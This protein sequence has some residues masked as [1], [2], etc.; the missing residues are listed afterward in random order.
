MKKSYPVFFSDVEIF[1]KNMILKPSFHV[2]RLMG[3]KSLDHR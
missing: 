1:Q 2:L 3:Y